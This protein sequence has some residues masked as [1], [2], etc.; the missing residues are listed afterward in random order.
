[1]PAT[2]CTRANS[3]LQVRQACTNSEED[4][5]RDCILML[6]AATG[7]I[8]DLNRNLLEL[9]GANPRSLVG[10]SL[11]D[12]PCFKGLAFDQNIVIGNDFMQPVRFDHLTILTKN[13]H[14]VPVDLFAHLF[15]NEGSA[16]IMIN[17]CDRS[18][19]DKTPA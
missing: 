14:L 8:L 17:F 10:K 5:S 16:V 7:K 4:P 11:W 6:D 18:A 13:G 12:V 3:A 1:M 9:L 2:K 15:R 19:S